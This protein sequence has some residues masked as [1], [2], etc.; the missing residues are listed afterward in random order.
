MNDGDCEKTRQKETMRKYNIVS[1]KCSKG[2][3]VSE[4]YAAVVE[5]LTYHK[6]LFD[7]GID[8]IKSS[9][10]L[11]HCLSRY[12]HII[13]HGVAQYP[14]EILSNLNSAWRHEN[15]SETGSLTEDELSELIKFADRR[16]MNLVIAFDQVEWEPGYVIEGTYGFKKAD[17]IYGP[18]EHENYLSNCVIIKKDFFGKTLLCYAICEEKYRNTQA[19]NDVIKA[20]GEITEEKVCYAPED[21]KE[22]GEWEKKYE[23]GKKRFEQLKSA[24]T[25]AADELPYRLSC[26]IPLGV[27]ETLPTI[28]AKSIANGVLKTSGW[29]K[30][31]GKYIPLAYK[32]EFP[33]GTVTFLIDIIRRG[34]HIQTLLEYES[35]FFSFEDSGVQYCEPSTEEEV[36]NYF[37]NLLILMKRIEESFRNG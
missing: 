4:L 6:V 20:L 36:E 2:V 11:L 32:K 17:Y 35:I 27:Y 14:M 10:K 29:E 18:G 31:K 7:T 26:H 30:T 13:L 12:R 23:E 37:K 16:K 5:N 34:H 15:K 28:N 3:K 1:L 22:R 25:A 24:L 33:S 21:E 19:F 8:I 9:E